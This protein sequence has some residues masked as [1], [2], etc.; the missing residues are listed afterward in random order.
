LDWRRA[1]TNIVLFRP[2]YFTFYTVYISEF[3]K[4]IHPIIQFGYGTDQVPVRLPVAHLPAALPPAGSEIQN[5]GDKWKVEALKTFPC[6]PFPV[7]F[8]RPCY[9]HNKMRY[10]CLFVCGLPM[11]G[12]TAGPIKTKLGIDH[13][14][15]MGVLVKVK[16]KVIYL[17]VRYNRIHDSDT[18]RTTT[19]H[20]KSISS[21]STS[22]VAGATWW[23]LI[24][25][26]TSA[27]QRPAGPRE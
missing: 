19:R 21:S 11:A 4:I 23:M 7:F 15:P 24:K 26:L 9:L 5:E 18:W 12:R 13:V 10:V 3:H 20:A 27:G 14:D 25:L 1:C 22:A 8:P 2:S 17:C 16:V 6:P